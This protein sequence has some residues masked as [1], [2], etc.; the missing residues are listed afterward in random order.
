MSEEPDVR[1][2][3]SAMLSVMLA[4]A[5]TMGCTVFLVML[6]GGFFLYVVAGAAMLFGFVGLHYLVWGR[7]LTGLLKTQI[8]E[9]ELMERVRD[10]E[11]PPP[12][13]AYRQR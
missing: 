2:Q 9:A 12:S 5:A 6:T 8:A 10:A 11:R 1:K 3:R 13:T 7:L 4:V